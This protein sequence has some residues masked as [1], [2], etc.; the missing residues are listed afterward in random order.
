[1]NLKLLDRFLKKW[2]SIKFHKNPPNGSR[3]VPRE[4]KGRHAERMR[5]RHDEAD[6]R[7][8]AIFRTSV[9]TEVLTNAA[10]FPNTWDPLAVTGLWQEVPRL[11]RNGALSLGKYFSEFPRMTIFICRV[12]Q[13]KCDWVFF[14]EDNRETFLRNVANYNL[15][16]LR[17][18]QGICAISVSKFSCVR[19][20]THTHK[21]ANERTYTH[22]QIYIH[23]NTHTH[24]HI[25][26]IYIYI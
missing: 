24:A 26:T 18:I 13:S 15:N 21:Q 16:I 7:F 14:S 2:S 17:N 10:G 3:V 1:M 11:L 9:I 22:T 8:F 5:D 4:R 19:T 6:T 25:Y 23:T 20:H 12:K